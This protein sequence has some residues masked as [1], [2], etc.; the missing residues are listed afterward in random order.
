MRIINGILLCKKLQY[1]LAI[2]IY[3]YIKKLIK[4]TQYN[5]MQ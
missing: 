2:Y 5:D 1:N 3:K 4:Y